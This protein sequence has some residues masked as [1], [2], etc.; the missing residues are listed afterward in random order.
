MKPGETRLVVAFS[1]GKDSTAMALRLHELGKPFRMIHTAT[2]N[3][4]PEVREHVIRVAEETGAD[5]I[6]LD[7]PTLEQLITEQQCLPSWRMRWCTRMIKIEP[8][9]EWLRLNQN[10]RLAVG[11]RSPCI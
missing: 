3:E 11:L 10:V 7:A 8:C 6:D 5:L 1:G 4:L 9:A 2:G